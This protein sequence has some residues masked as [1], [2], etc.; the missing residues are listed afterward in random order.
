M[1]S[2]PEAASK[3][4]N[5]P[6]RAAGGIRVRPI[7]GK[8]DPGTGAFIYTYRVEVPASITGKRTL[9][10]FKT[11]EE[12]NAYASLMHVQ[13]QNQGLAGFSL[14]DSERSD[15]RRAIDLLK[16]FPKVTLTAAVEF[17]RKHFM[18][19]GGDITVLKLIDLYVAQKESEK[20]KE[21]SL[22]DLE[23]RLKRLRMA[24]GDRL[25]KELGST[26]LKAWIFDDPTLE[27]QSKKNYR[28]VL[29]GLFRF[30]KEKKYVVDNPAADLPK[31]KVDESEPGILSVA[32]ARTLLY[33]AAENP[34][35]ELGPYV[36]LGLFCGI[37]SAELQ[38]L[39]WSEVQL[40]DG[41]VTI[42]ARIAKKRR[43]RNIPLEPN[44][45]AWLNQFGVRT[46]GPI[47]PEGF[48]KRFR[49][50]VAKANEFAAREAKAGKFAA[51]HFAAI[52]EWPNNGLRHSFA[53]YYYAWT[54]NSQ[55]TCA[56]LGQKSDEVLFDHY[57][58]LTR[59]EAGQQFFAITPPATAPVVAFPSVAVVEPPT[60]P[61]RAASL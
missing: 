51:E 39:S 28:T 30:A 36:A 32:Q 24:F 61:L 29:H 48:A 45:I 22:A 37:R 26:E 19:E 18:P 43:I 57:R 56:R 52:K 34:D 35:L 47:S 58:A 49:K 12:A 5:R 44:C 15:A 31:I 17:Y 55:E 27:A 1:S 4:R 9:K 3:E 33:A 11:P 59:R 41:F 14:S 53:S 7:K 21:R 13:R 38:R 20:L 6:W 10:I 54:G 23:S 42:P 50:L 40:G 46:S 25:V 8:R 2:R 60:V 16:P